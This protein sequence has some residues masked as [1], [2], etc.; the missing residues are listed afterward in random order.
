MLKCRDSPFA[1]VRRKSNFLYACFLEIEGLY[2]LLLHSQRLFVQLTPTTCI[3]SLLILEL[4]YSWC[5]CQLLLLLLI[6]LLG[7]GGLVLKLIIR[8][9]NVAVSLLNV[10]CPVAHLAWGESIRIR[11]YS[12]SCPVVGKLKSCLWFGDLL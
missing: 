12:L 7:A 9:S 2:C 3:L 4:E 11:N 6:S 8:S 5:L 10:F 1:L